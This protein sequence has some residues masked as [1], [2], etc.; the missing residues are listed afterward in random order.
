MRRQIR[1][2]WIVGSMVAAS[3][4]LSLQPVVASPRMVSLAFNSHLQNPQQVG[5]DTL[6]Q[7]LQALAGKRI[8]LDERVG[9]ALGSEN[10]I[11]AATRSG[12]VDVAV[13]SGGVVSGAIPEMGVFDIPFL[14]R[15]VAHAK[16]V[17]QGPVGAAI[18]AKFADKGLVLLALGKQGFRDITNSK[19]PIRSP[20]DLKGLKFRVIPNPI[21][22]MTF[23]ALGAEVVPMEFPLVYAALKDGRLDGQENPPSTMAASRFNEVQKYLTLSDHFFAPIA[24]VANRAMFEQLDPSDQEALIAAAKAGA[25]ATWQSQLDAEKLEQLRRAGMDVIDKVD[26]QPFIDALKPLEPEFEKRFGKDLLAA[27]RSTR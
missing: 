2:F 1:G 20:D 6:R 13:L 23:K 17:M 10:A 5:S 14:F 12:A 9:G 26:R 16:A 18:A 8:I 22:Q 7:K 15:D 27:I 4:L 3:A 25:E 19:R 24:F 21:Y 11:L